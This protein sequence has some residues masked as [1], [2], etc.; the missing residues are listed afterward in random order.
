MLGSHQQAASLAAVDQA[1]LDAVATTEHLGHVRL[2]VGQGL[3]LC[4][5]GVL[6]D[7]RR[8]DPRGGLR[9]GRPPGSHGHHPTTAQGGQLGRPVQSRG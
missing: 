1:H 7:R 3:C 6:G 2:Q 9:W 5:A 8:G 4:G